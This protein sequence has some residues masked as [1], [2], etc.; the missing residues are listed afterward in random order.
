MEFG[1]NKNTYRLLLNPRA[2]YSEFK[3]IKIIKKYKDKSLTIGI[4]AKINNSNIGNHVYLGTN[5]QLNNS[6]LGNHSY[7]NSNTRISYAKV[8]KFCSIGPNVIIGMGIHPTHLISTHPAFYS[9]NKVFKTFADK[10]Y[11]REYEET[12]IGND[13]WI[14]SHVKII[15]G[16]SIEDGAIIAAGAIV[17]KDVRPYEVVGGIPAKHIKFRFNENEISKLRSFKWW[18]KDDAWLEAHYKLFLDSEKFLE[19]LEKNE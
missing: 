17:T 11:F 12:V 8:G 1:I 3:R 4:N 9:N 7:V 14:G 15:G 18:N 10:N 16:I 19:Y 13:V 6:E 5:A 2:F